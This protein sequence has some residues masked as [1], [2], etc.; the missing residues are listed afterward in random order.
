MKAQWPRDHEPY[1][2]KYFLRTKQI[3]E[4]EGI[5]PRVTFKVFCRDSFTLGEKTTGRIKGLFQEIPRDGVEARIRG[6]GTYSPGEP[7]ALYEGPAQDLV[8][9]ETV[10]LGQLSHILT[11]EYWEPGGTP[12]PLR[13]KQRVNKVASIYDRV[14]VPLLYFGARH[15]SWRKDKELA[16]YA[17]QAG[18]KQT[19]TY[20]GS[21]NIYK[22]GVGT[23]P[24][25]LTILL[26]SVYGKPD[27]TRHTARLF[28]E[29]MPEDVPRTILIDT[30]NRELS[31]SLDALE[32]LYSY[33]GTP[34]LRIDTCGE[35]VAETGRREMGSDPPFEAG[36]GVT[37]ESV[38]NLRE[39]LLDR[40]YRDV[41]LFVSSGMGKP[42]KALAFAE[43]QED[44]EEQHG[45]KMFHGVGA[46]DFAG[47]IQCTADPFLVDGEPLAKAGREIDP[48]DLEQ[49]EFD[50]VSSYTGVNEKIEA[51]R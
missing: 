28:D 36:R 27:A 3:L 39:K 49:Y 21:S 24:H 35:N 37:V 42:E 4:A 8:D 32:E 17:L 18:A 45:V 41:K 38:W 34:G 11:R 30:F 20:I 31:D 2:D 12:W 44:F 5:N 26:A 23:T 33:P 9:L 14:G 51:L 19:S 50:A 40:G 16:G 46:G 1:T 29:H 43:A 13:F 25:V 10:L 48:D 7:L 15:Y 6:P 47:T 22:D